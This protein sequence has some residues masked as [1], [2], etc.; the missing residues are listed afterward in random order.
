MINTRSKT[1]VKIH[2]P[3]GHDVFPNGISIANLYKTFAVRIDE[4]QGVGSTFKMAKGQ[5]KL[6]PQCKECDKQK[7]NS[8]RCLE[9]PE[10]EGSQL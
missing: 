5:M 1:K 6:L 9:V 2:C 8:S 10:R 7:I 3:K 4:S